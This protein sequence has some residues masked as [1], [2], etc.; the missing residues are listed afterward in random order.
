MRHGTLLR[1]HIRGSAAAEAWRRGNVQ[2]RKEKSLEF[3]QEERRQ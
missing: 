2:L 1:V 3:A